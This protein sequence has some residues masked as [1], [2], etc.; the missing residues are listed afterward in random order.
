M[1]KNLLSVKMIYETNS[2]LISNSLLSS[3]HLKP[4]SKLMIDHIQGKLALLF[5]FSFFLKFLMNKLY[6][7]R[8]R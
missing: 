7:Y 5:D 8:F 2:I 6:G 4:I 3:S 1:D